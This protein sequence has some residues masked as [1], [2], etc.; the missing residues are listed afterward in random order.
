MSS[1]KEKRDKKPKKKS[2]A[3]IVE[4]MIEKFEKKLKEAQH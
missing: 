1:Q 4:K 3:V 2:K